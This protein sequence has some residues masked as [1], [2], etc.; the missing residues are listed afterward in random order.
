M[1]LDT[2]VIGECLRMLS[3]HILSS[4]LLPSSGLIPPLCASTTRE[5]LLYLDIIRASVVNTIDGFWTKS[6]CGFSA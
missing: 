2:M 4:K 5:N 6:T 1:P 3:A